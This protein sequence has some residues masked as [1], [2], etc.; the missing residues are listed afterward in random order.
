MTTCVLGHTPSLRGIRAARRKYAALPW[1]EIGKVEQRNALKNCLPVSCFPDLDHLDMH[2]FYEQPEGEPLHLLVSDGAHIS[3][4]QPLAC[5]V[6]SKPLPKGAIMRVDRDLYAL[7]PA[8]TA[9]LYARKITLAETLMLLMELLGTY[10]LPEAATMS[11]HWGGHWHQDDSDDSLQQVHYKC[12]P[13]TDITELRRLARWTKSSSDSTF[14]E[15][16]RIAAAGSA[17]PGESMMFGMFNAPMRHG[18]FGFSKFPKGGM[19]LNHRIDFDEQSLH[20]AS[21]IPYAVCDAYIPAARNCFEYNGIGHEEPGYRIHDGER[22]N[23][24]KGMGIKVIAINR[25]QMRDIVALEAIARST[26]KD[27]GIRFQYRVSGYRARQTQWLNGL[28]KGCG[29]RPA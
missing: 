26:Y 29:L 23:G 12:E 7:S 17:S 20:M 21:G 27:A 19:L 24:L 1:R 13:A 5:H 14:R 16:V 22:N 28:R 2:G 18:G 6:W 15:A 9:L 3:K 8:F 10:T 11:L 25:K 4:R